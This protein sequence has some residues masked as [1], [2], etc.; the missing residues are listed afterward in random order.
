MDQFLIDLTNNR[1][2]EVKVVLTVVVVAL[3]VYQVALAAVVYGKVKLPFLSSRSASYTHRSMGDTIVPL[4]LFVAF[5]CLFYFEEPFGEATLHAILGVL[6]FV[7]L[8]L[9]IVVLRWW[10]SMGR[11]LPTLGGSV[12]ILFVLTAATAFGGD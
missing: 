2:P 9:K 7:A 12:L 1:V 4:G 8:A 11:F 6:L 3:A 10:H 5:A